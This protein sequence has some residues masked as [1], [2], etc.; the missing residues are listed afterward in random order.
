MA[1][2]LKRLCMRSLRTFSTLTNNKTATN[3]CNWKFL[4]SEKWPKGINFKNY[5]IKRSLFI[6]TQETP[7]PNSLK[8]L[9]G[10]PVLESG[11]FDVPNISTA[12]KSP[13]ARQ[14]FQIEG[15]TAVFFGPDFITVSKADDDI[16]WKVLKPQIYATIMDFF[17]TGLPVVTAERESSEN[18]ADDDDDETVQMIKELLET[19]IRP[20]VQEDGGDIIYKGFEDGIVKLKMLGACTSCPSSVV[21]LKSGVENMLQFYIPEVKGVLQVTDEVD[22][23]AEKEFK[24]LEEKLKGSEE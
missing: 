3:N 17:A 24:K 8:F 15:V 2:I 5:H 10:V 12:S 14:L 6:Q 16:E 1:N 22:E 9:P 18:D 23:I 11:T 21:T 4:V 20:V 7:N 13:L 19:R